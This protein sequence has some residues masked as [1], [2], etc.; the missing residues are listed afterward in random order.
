MSEVSAVQAPKVCDVMTTTVVAVRE[1]ATYKEIADA[2]AEFGVGAVP[3]L[4]E[5]DRVVGL[6]SEADVLPKVEFAGD[7]P[8]PPLFARL[9]RRR[10]RAKPAGDTA[11]ALMTS[12]AITIGPDSSI[13][14]AARLMEDARVK[15]LPVVGDE[16]RLAGIVTRRD[17]LRAFLR[18]DELT[19]R[20]DDG[21]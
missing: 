5:D 1:R 9:R 6:V 10:A 14:D 7:E 4:D 21:G 15:R 12:P 11:G 17:L 2:L 18:L 8:R 16:G 13:M 3:V 20:H 19:C